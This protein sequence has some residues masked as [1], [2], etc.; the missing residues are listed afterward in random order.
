MPDTM[1]RFLFLWLLVLVASASASAQIDLRGTLS[2]ALTNDPIGFATVYLDGTSIG[3]VSADD[4][5]FRI[6]VPAGRENAT[7]I[8]S[9]LNYRTI[10]VSLT[11]QEQ[12]LELQLRPKAAILTSIEVADDDLRAD[13]LKE[14][15]DRLIGNDAWGRKTTF[16]NDEV[17]R[18]TRDARQVTIRVTSEEMAERLRQRTYRNPEWSEDGKQLT[19]DRPTNLRAVTT[20]ALRL[21]LPHLGYE[22]HLDLQHFES[23]YRNNRMSYLGTTYFIP[24]TLANLRQQ[25]RYARARREAYYG[26]SLHFIRSMLRDSL[27]ENG[28]QVVEVVKEASA[29]K[30]AQTKP[31]NLQDY[32]VNL[33]NN[34]YHLKGLEDRN[35][36]VL[37]YGNRNTPGRAPSLRDSPSILQSRMVLIGEQSTLYF[38]GAQ[39]DTNLLFSGDIGVR[40]IAW[41]L[42]LDYW[43]DK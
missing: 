20:S 28:F 15:H 41:A 13:N 43:P 26:S 12:N 3:D 37:Y 16:Q 27:R 17:I 40:A 34:T 30:T 33:G 18:F 23:N 38:N 35:V 14:F 32:I 42:P 9:H 36:A 8:V 2:D 22:L 11:P 19:Y 10:A 6:K 1:P 5:S 25:R 31:I 29:G 4:G 24:D 7:M 39:A 21:N